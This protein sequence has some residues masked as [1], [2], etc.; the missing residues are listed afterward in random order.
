MAQAAKQ[1][2]KIKDI[3]AQALQEQKEKEESNRKRRNR[4]RDRKKKN[5]DSNCYQYVLPQTVYVLKKRHLLCL[6]VLEGKR[7]E[8]L[9]ESSTYFIYDTVT[10]SEGAA[11]CFVYASPKDCHDHDDDGSSCFSTLAEAF[12]LT[13]SDCQSDSKANMSQPRKLKLK[14]PFRVE[15][16]PPQVSL[17]RK[18]RPMTHSVWPAEDPGSIWKLRF[19]YRELHL[20]G[21]A[22]YSALPGEPATDCKR[23]YYP[24]TSS[25]AIGPPD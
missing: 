15:I 13:S 2:K 12:F 11:V 7:D 24:V 4:S 14:N 3:E 6:T 16:T 22:L 1:L 5:A 25:E 20:R 23:M 18:I 19:R 17:Y 10:V 8:L 9:S 21:K